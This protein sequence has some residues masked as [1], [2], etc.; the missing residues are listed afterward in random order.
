[1]LNEI[2]HIAV[3]VQDLE[4]ALGIYRDALGFPLLSIEEVPAEGVKVAFLQLPGGEGHIEL[5]QPTQPGT[6]IARFLE[7]RGEG[8]HHICFRVADIAAAMTHLTGNGMQMIEQE[9]R[10][11]RQGQKYAFVH[12]KTAHG[13]LIELYERP[14]SPSG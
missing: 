3:V 6:G 8:F 1:M 2:E 9:A 5:V 11:G 14:S 7:K 10:T 4:A 13:V 12:P